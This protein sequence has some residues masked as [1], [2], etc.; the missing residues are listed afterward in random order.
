E[1]TDVPGVVAVSS[2]NQN[3]LS[4]GNNTGDVTWKGKDP[5]ADILV[6]VMDVDFGF[7]E[8]MGMELKEGRFFD[9]RF[10][11]DTAAF[12]INEEAARQMNME[13]PIG[14]WLSI[15]NEGHIV[16]VVKDFHSN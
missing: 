3:P 12:I 2:A 5:N 6:D 15:W 8:L 7:E 10:G 4:M 16:G 14:Q 13:K 1:L 9:K 11:T